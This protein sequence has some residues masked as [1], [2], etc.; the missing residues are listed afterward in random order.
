MLISDRGISEFDVRQNVAKFEL[1]KAFYY[2]IYLAVVVEVKAD[3]SSPVCS[4][5]Y[6][7]RH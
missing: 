6:V 5:S 1:R 3:L 2:M 7:T 4:V